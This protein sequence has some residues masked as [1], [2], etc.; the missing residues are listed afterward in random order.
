MKQANE[1]ALLSGAT[2]WVTGAGSGLGRAIVQ[3][4]VEQGNFVIVSGRRRE[5]LTQLSFDYGNQVKVV[6]CDVSDPFSLSQAQ[7]EI[8]EITDYLDC[9]IACA[10]L[11]EYEDNVSLNIDMYRA[12]ME[13]NFLGAVSTLNIAKPLLI[14]SERKAVFVAVGSLVSQLPFPRAEAYGA[15]KA[16]L[17]YWI[18]SLHTDLHDASWRVCLVRPGFVKTPMT[19][20]NDFEMPFLQTPEQGA[21]AIINGIA[22]GRLIVDFPRRFSLMLRFFSAVEGVWLRWITPKMSRAQHHNTLSNRHL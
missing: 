22:S 18:K 12:A 20:Q 2:V 10:G 3:R 1:E 14:Q 8:F 11:C 9:V 5:L 4:L 15:S 21:Q 7:K 6:P 17:E 16:A 19:S 13:V